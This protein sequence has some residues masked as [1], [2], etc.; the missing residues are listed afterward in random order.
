MRRC[1]AQTGIRTLRGNGCAEQ[2]GKLAHGTLTQFAVFDEQFTRHGQA[3]NTRLVLTEYGFLCILHARHPT[4]NYPAAVRRLQRLRRV[5]V[6]SLVEQVPVVI[7]ISVVQRSRSRVKVSQ[8]VRGKR[9]QR[10]IVRVVTPLRTVE[11]DG[12]VVDQ[13]EIGA[14]DHLACFGLCERAD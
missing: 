4:Q 14:F 2:G 6:E 1:K 7:Q 11:Q 5:K 10:E 12:D 13:K 8:L 3:V 9:V